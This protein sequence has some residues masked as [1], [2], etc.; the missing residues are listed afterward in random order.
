M[1]ATP[2]ETILRAVED[3]GSALER[4]FRACA[5]EWRDH[6]CKETKPFSPKP[7]KDRSKELDTWLQH[8][9]VAE[10]ERPSYVDVRQ[11]ALLGSYFHPGSFEKPLEPAERTTPACAPDL[12]QAI[13][14]LWDGPA[15]QAWRLLLSRGLQQIRE[16]R[17]NG[18]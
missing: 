11:Q 17:R 16:R 6:G 9:L 2:L 15:E 5:A 13:A 1:D 12:Q 14:D 8:V 4:A 10:Q 3:G 7:R 18:V